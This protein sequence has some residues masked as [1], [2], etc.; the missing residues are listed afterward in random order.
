MLTLYAGDFLFWLMPVNTFIFLIPATSNF[1]NPAL[2]SHER[3]PG[4][5]IALKVFYS[6]CNPYKINADFLH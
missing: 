5:F 6:T 3:L 4:L 2:V 1:L